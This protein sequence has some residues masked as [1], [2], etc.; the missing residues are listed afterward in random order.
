MK[1]IL[2][3]D[4][5]LD[6]QL[7]ELKC[8][9]MP[10]FEIVGKFTNPDQAIAYAAGHVV[11]FALLD[12]DMPGMN[13]MEL[14]QRLRQIRRDI[15][16][17]FATAH[18]KFAVDALRMKADYMIFKPFDR[19]DI[20][21]VMERAKLLRRRQNKR[22]FFRTFGAFDMLVDGEPVRFRS[23]KAKELMALCLYRQ[24]CPASIHEIVEC[25]WGEETAGA[26]RTGY[27]RT[28]KELT[29]TLRDYA[30]EE[31]LLRARGSLQLRLELVDS[32]YQRFLDGD[33]DAICQFQGSFLRQYSWAEPMVY[34]LLEK[35]QLMLA[36]LSRR[37]ESQ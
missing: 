35:K 36:R 3:D 25:M 37:G 32:D 26:D 29:D 4:M 24:G 28:I 22:F 17:V 7:F 31:L 21:D 14:A 19:E 6:L 33:P 9:D 27:R 20:A 10:D 1:T 18:P 16:I 5:L 13:G 34:T 30:A 15:I 11:D 8:A 12:I 23:A 2:V